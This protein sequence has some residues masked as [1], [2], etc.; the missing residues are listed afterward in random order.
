MQI[1]HSLLGLAVLTSPVI[2]MASNTAFSVGGTI[3]AVLMHDSNV[4]GVGVNVPANA[5]YN[6]SNHSDTKLDASLSQLRFGSNTELSSGDGLS[7]KVVMDFNND[8]NSSMSPRL[9]EAYLRWQT[10]AGDVTAGQTWSTFMDMRNYPKTLV[11]PTLSGVVFKRQPQIRWSSDIGQWKYELAIEEGTNSDIVDAAESEVTGNSIDTSGSLPDFVVALEW[12]NENAWV[13]ATSA[14]SN[15]RL[16]NDGAHQSVF[17]YGVQLSGGIDITERDRFTLL[18]NHVEGMERYL[19]GLSGIGPTW[20]ANQSRIELYRTSS[21]M[22]SITHGWSDTVSSTLAYSYVEP[23]QPSALHSSEAFSSTQYGYVNVLWDAEENL[24]LGIEY[25]YA[26]FERTT[27]KSE[28]NHRLLVG[29][30]W[31]Y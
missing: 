22:S 8:N 13:R 20:N 27:N 23:E 31:T 24:T 3:H 15:A 19:L 12:T 6:K 11:E 2:V 26:Q 10:P 30:K 16:Y 17:I 25:Q 1:K 14:M 4:A 21:V 29:V 28:D 18:L 5:L 7:T 9:R